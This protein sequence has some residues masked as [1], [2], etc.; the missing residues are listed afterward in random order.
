MELLLMVDAAKGAAAA[1]ITAVIPHYAYA[2]SDKKDASRISLGGRLV[3]DMLTTAGVTRVLTMT[4]HAPAGARL[5]LRPG[6]PPHRARRARRPLPRPGPRATRSSSRRTSATPR[7]RPSS[8]GCSALPVAAGSKQRLAD[9]RVVIDDDRRRRRRQAGDRARRRD[10]HR[11]LD[12]RA[13]GQARRSSA[14]P[15]PRS[16]ARTGCSS[17]RPSTGS[18]A[19]R[20]SSEVVTTDTVPPADWPELRVRSVADAV[21]RGDRPDPRRRVGQQPVR[22]RRPHT[23]PAAAPAAV[24][25]LSAARCAEAARRTPPSGFPRHGR[26][27]PCSTR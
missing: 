8:P 27:T 24:P 3:A 12:R 10:R 2:R 26:L 22:R 6:R 19:T 7:P 15:V 13:A 9:D 25:G 20:S 16:P 1:Q 11:R 23:R 5:L 18:A 17:A 4:L 14:A 21:R